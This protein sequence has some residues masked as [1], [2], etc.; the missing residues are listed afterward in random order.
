M[1]TSSNNI[2]MFNIHH[3]SVVVRSSSL[4]TSL[5][6]SLSLA[7]LLGDEEENTDDHVFKTEQ[8]RDGDGHG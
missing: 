8:E 7:W 5:V 4:T 2:C 6:S 3:P 1:K